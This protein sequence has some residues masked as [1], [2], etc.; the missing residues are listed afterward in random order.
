[1]DNFHTVIAKSNPRLNSETIRIGNEMA[2]AL[3][4]QEGDKVSLFAGQLS[5]P[6][7]ICINIHKSERSIELSPVNFRRLHI[8]A[9]RSY[10][11]RSSSDGIYIGPVVG[12]M[13][14]S[15][16]DNHRPFGGQSLFISQLIN[17]GREMGEICFAF[18]TNSIDFNRKIIYGYTHGKEGWRKRIFPIP[19]VIYPREG[20]YSPAKLKIRRRLQS[21]GCSF[22]NPPLIGKWETHKILS[23]NPILGSYM[24]D[25][26]LVTSFHEVDRMLKKYGAVYMKPINGSMGRNIIRV[27]KK[28]NINVYEYQY[29]QNS[30]PRL[31]T[32]HGLNSLRHSLGRFMGKR[33][34][35]VQRRI[36]LVRMNGK[37]VD[38]RVLVQKENAGKWSVTGKACR[39]GRNGSITSNISAGGSG[40]KVPAVLARN[41]TDPIQR[42]R[43]MTE[44]D[45]VALEA[46]QAL[47][48]NISNIGELGIDIGIDRNGQLWFIEANLRPARHVFNLIG[49]PATRRK[50]VQRPLLYARYLA[51]FSQERQE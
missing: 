30:Q 46:A 29:Q 8:S 31:G 43:I 22:I 23:Q 38:V 7:N 4:L 19:D 2:Q 34:Y 49:E 11:I 44:L 42:E 15:N 12:I 21:M 17:L 40:E 28:K 51:G 1:M 32:V 33:R 13:A 37:I 36:N 16:G 47:E 50:S 25:T 45:H 5:T 14:D 18:S 9:S 3:G 10:G 48:S 35:I 26:Q 20:G 39:I 27:I 24:P 6:R 41:F